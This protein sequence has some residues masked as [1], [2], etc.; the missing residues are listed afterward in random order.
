MKHLII[1]SQFILDPI[2]II[3]GISIVGVFAVLTI[4][5]IR[6][7]LKYGHFNPFYTKKKYL[8]LIAREQRE[9]KEYF[10]AMEY[11][12]QKEIEDCQDSEINQKKIDE[13]NHLKV[14]NQ[15]YEST[16]HENFNN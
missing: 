3:I 2:R 4:L 1:H 12:L 9:T 10:M 16:E 5:S 6:N 11:R 15:Q 7:T 13:L 14:L 8:A